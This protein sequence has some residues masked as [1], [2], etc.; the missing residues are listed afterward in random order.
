MDLKVV[1]WVDFDSNYPMRQLTQEE[2]GVLLQ[3]L[4]NEIV[5]N[6]YS[7]SGE[8]H[9]N[10]SCG[11]PVFS[12]GTC[13]RASMRAWGSL[14]ADIHEGPGGMQL[15]YMDFYMDVFGERKM[16]LCESVSIE[17]AQVDVELPGLIIK[18][19]MELIEQTLSFG[20]EFM[21]TDKVLNQIYKNLKK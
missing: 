5:E 18:E 16:P 20:M 11:M 2:L 15:S 8:D 9:Q 1:G 3:V 21:T 4:R 12:D 7:F 17:P 14:M 19:D 13:L 6:G 10:S